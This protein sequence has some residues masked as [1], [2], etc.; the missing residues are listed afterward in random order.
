MAHKIYKFDARG[1]VDLQDALRVAGEPGVM[2]RHSVYWSHAFNSYL[3]VEAPRAGKGWGLRFERAEVPVIVV[4]VN[5]C[6]EVRWQVDGS[7][8]SGEDDEVFNAFGL[9]AKPQ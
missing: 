4:S 9:T 5:G 6:G 8:F 7:G 1:R 2:D 3:L